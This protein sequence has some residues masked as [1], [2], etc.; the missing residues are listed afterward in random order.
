MRLVHPL[1]VSSLILLTAVAL[2]ALGLGGDSVPYET[3]EYEIVERLDSVE[4]R[5]YRPYLAAETTVDG[6]LEKAGNRGF[7]VLAKYIFGGN[8]S[9][10]KIAMTSPVTQKVSGGE[11]I[12]M[13]APVTQKRTDGQYVVQFMMPSEYS[14]EALPVPNDARVN[15]REVPGRRVAAVRYSGTWSKRN[16]EKHLARLIDTLRAGG[17][18][19]VGEPTWARYNPPFT[20]WFLRRN[21]IMTEF[22][23]LPVASRD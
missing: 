23:A 12:A 6:D 9:A 8:R 3:P 15:I 22:R 21:E 2:A 14:K 13:T 4:I 18:A 20:P 5:D 16:Y 19:A 10:K 17:Y 11:K 7:P 1:K